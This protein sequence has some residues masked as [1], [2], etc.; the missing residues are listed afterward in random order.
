MSPTSAVLGNLS[1]TN[2]SSRP[3]ISNPASQLF[4]SFIGGLCVG[5]AGLAVQKAD[6]VI[7]R[8]E[9][10]DIQVEGDTV[11]RHHCRIRRVGNAFLLE[12]NSRN[13]TF[14]NG[15]RIASAQLRDQDQVRVG[16]N[17]L[18]INLSSNSGT[19]T[20]TGK[21][22]T[23]NLLP[24]L[25]ELRPH[26]VVKGLEVGVTQPFGE[27]RITIGRRGDNHLVIDADNISRQHLCVERQGESYVATDMGS[28]NG[29]YLNNER[30]QCATLKDGDCL[31]IGNYTLTVRL[32][33]QDCILSFKQIT[34]S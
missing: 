7:G 11:S 26:I 6:C 5:Q 17:V 2:V 8:G 25:L 30:I 22:T 32:R 27:E 28:S 14:L 15:E 12:D 20:L 21:N 3:T 34:K 16:Q 18:L 33:G 31:R 24:Y 4:I 1:G 19:N 29:T 13:G 23:P 10:C 9:D